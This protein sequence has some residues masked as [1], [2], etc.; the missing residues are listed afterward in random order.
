MKRSSRLAAIGALT[1]SAL[2]FAGSA[3]PAYADDVTT[4]VGDVHVP[5][6]DQVAVLDTGVIGGI[7]GP[8]GVDTGG[9][10]ANPGGRGVR[11]SVVGYISATNTGGSPTFTVSGALADPTLWSCSAGTTATGAYAVTCTPLPNVVLSW[12]C[13]VLHADANSMSED[14]KVRTSMDC[15]GDATPEAATDVAHGLGTSSHQS[16]WATADIPVSSFVCTFDDGEGGRGR[17]TWGGGCGDPGVP[18][19]E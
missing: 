12:D 1:L 19:L 18:E 4:P 6:V 10:V 7:K 5:I 15:T 17:G 11:G 3:A 14:G 13:D 9:G 2:C 16:V 8:G